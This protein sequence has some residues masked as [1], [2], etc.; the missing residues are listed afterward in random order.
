MTLVLGHPD[1]PMSDAYL[2]QILQQG[3]ATALM[4]PP[5]FLEALSQDAVGLEGLMKL[6]HIAYGGGPLRPDI[7]ET[8]T[9]AVPHLASFI[10]ATEYGWFHCISGS[11]ENSD[12]LNFYSDIGYKF[13]EIA[14]KQFELVIVNDARTNHFHGIFDVFPHLAA[15]RTRDVYMAKPGASGWW[16]YKGRIDDLIVLSNGEKINPI[17]MENIVASHP[18]V[19]AALMV[20]EYRFN[21]SLLVELENVQAAATETARLEL[22]DSIWPTVQ[23][24]NE[25]AP[26]FAK[27]S[28]SLVLFAKPDKPFLRA[29]KGTVQRKLTIQS[30]MEELDAL[31]ASQHD[32]LLLEG[33]EIR[34]LASVTDIKHLVSQIIHQT[35]EI[36]GLSDSD[37]IFHFGLDSLKV[38]MVSRRL[39]AALK[40]CGKLHLS[41]LVNNRL[42]YAFPSIE[43]MANQ[44]VLLDNSDRCGTGGNERFIESRAHALE[45]LLTRFAEYQIPSTV[46]S[47]VRGLHGGKPWKVIL[48]G[49][50]GSLGSY[51]L[52]ALHAL[53]ETQVS[54]IFCLN[55]S[56]DG[57]ERQ[58]K[59]NASRGIES[60]WADG[61]RVQFLH[62]DLAQEDLGLSEESLQMLLDETTVI[63]HAAW[64]VNF[65]LGLSSFEPHIAGVRNLLNF[66]ARSTH[67]A[68][69]IFISSISTTFSWQDR[70]P[71][72]RV[73]EGVLCDFDAPETSGYAESKF[74]SELLIEKIATSAQLTT[75]ILRVG[76]IAGPVEGTEGS[77]NKQEWFP[78][79][80][81][82]SKHLGVLP[83]T[84]GPLGDIDWIPVDILAPVII[85]LVEGILHSD[86]AHQNGKTFVYNLVNP[87]ISSWTSHLNAVQRATAIKSIIPLSEWVDALE[88]SSFDKG[89]IVSAA[90]PAVKL[91]DFFHRLGGRESSVGRANVTPRYDVSLLLE[92]SS[93]ASHMTAVSDDWMELWIKQWN[94]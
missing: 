25:I 13:D 66:S 70:H 68:A 53:P 11:N 3:V 86:P 22:L 55:R 17:A 71:D 41:T 80:I 64:P 32:V 35:L 5:T 12:A 28:K 75:S 51:L 42:V 44:L 46:A 67:R 47:T 39:G 6:N 4:T 88:K 49:S 36:D 23:K 34:Q 59:A 79:L 78:S 77:W 43:K 27:M 48:T 54:K 16:T 61:E 58:I 74:V 52:A 56:V 93:S 62:V 73:P 76:Q 90:H 24:A 26:G 84:M 10:G 89:G 2:S 29:G 85:E 33:L 83:S 65:N 18:A 31:A 40:A 72:Q 21:A 19:K 7:I 91:L 92:N 57:G 15:Y 69:F 1:I 8:L 37:D 45:S 14:N 60:S 30:Y 87:K 82:S 38:N 94:F 81:A 63:I 50:T 20:G 9:P